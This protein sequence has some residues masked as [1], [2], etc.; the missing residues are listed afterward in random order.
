MAWCIVKKKKSLEV[1]FGQAF[2]NVDGRVDLREEIFGIEVPVVVLA[3]FKDNPSFPED[4]K[5]MNGSGG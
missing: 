2:E 4:K 3:S 1:T 5:L